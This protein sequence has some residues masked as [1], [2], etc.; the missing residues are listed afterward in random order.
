M[1]YIEQQIAQP[2]EQMHDCRLLPFILPQREIHFKAVI[3]LLT[4]C[5]AEVI[6]PDTGPTPLG[7]TNYKKRWGERLRLKG[8]R[9]WGQ[10]AVTPLCVFV[11]SFLCGHSSEAALRLL[12]DVCG[13]RRRETKHP[14][15]GGLTGSRLM[16]WEQIGPWLRPLLNWNPARHTAREMNCVW[17]ATRQG[18]CWCVTSGR[19]RHVFVSSQCLCRRTEQRQCRT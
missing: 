2:E 12:S 6:A 7:E 5:R 4:P 15:V 10:P 3:G 1:R 14:G 9:P 18:T 17:A 13:R 19:S 8:P 16:E 11:Y